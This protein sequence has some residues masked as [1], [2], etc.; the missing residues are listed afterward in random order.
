MCSSFLS[1][2][3][4]LACSSGYVLR[5]IIICIPG[6]LTARA[7]AFARMAHDFPPPNLL[8]L[9]RP[10]AGDALLKT[11]F[12]FCSACQVQYSTHHPLI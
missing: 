8:H 3:M 1:G 6:H 2:L 11:V 9:R 4:W 5:M 7:I 12:A 10:H